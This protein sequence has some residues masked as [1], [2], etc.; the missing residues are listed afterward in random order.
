GKW[1]GRYRYD[2]S[3]ATSLF[4]RTTYIIMSY[5]I[6]ESSI[7]IIGMSG[8]FPG[9]SNIR[10]FWQNLI[11]GKKSIRT[12]SEAELLTA[13]TSPEALCKP[14]FVRAGTLLDGVNRFDASFF[15]LTP[16]EAEI[17]DPQV[18]LFLECSWE[19]LEDAGYDP[20]RYSGL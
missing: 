15:G 18:R 11:G 16:R 13:G 20:K 14:N 10:T 4:S 1:T 17:M 3:F 5:N 8:R 9:A 12:F 7:A 2:V 19:A 6:S